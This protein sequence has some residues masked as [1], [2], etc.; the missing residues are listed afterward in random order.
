MFFTI[1]KQTLANTSYFNLLCSRISGPCRRQ[2]LMNT[3]FE[4][5]HVK[6]HLNIPLSNTQSSLRKHHVYSNAFLTVPL[7]Y[8]KVT[9][10]PIDDKIARARP[11]MR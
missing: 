11:N 8:R 10:Y 7:L 6:I 9:R 5:I 3:L 1:F 4:P 2:H